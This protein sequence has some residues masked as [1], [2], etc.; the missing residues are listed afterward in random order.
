MVR[1][2]H[3]NTY[4]QFQWERSSIPSV[5]IQNHIPDLY[6]Y[7]DIAYDHGMVVAANVKFATGID[8]SIFL[9]TKKIDLKK[10]SGPN[11][12]PRR[13]EL[14]FI[15]IMKAQGD[16]FFEDNKQE[17]SDE[18]VSHSTYMHIFFW[19]VAVNGTESI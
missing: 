1:T 9:E 5:P 10:A 13:D 14:Y 15:E 17:W 11:S 19:I 6:F 8:S 2:S 12:I 4:A 18:D 7:T 3:H 16:F